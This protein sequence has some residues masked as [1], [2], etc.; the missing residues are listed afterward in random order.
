[1]QTGDAPAVTVE[2][3][4]LKLGEGADVGPVSVAELLGSLLEGT[5]FGAEFNLLRGL[6]GSFSSL[7]AAVQG[8]KLPLTVLVLA[9]VALSLLVALFFTAGS[10]SSSSS[11]SKKGGSAT[12]S[13]KGGSAAVQED[14][15][16]EPQRDFTLDQLREFTGGE[17]DKPIY[18]SLRG[19]VYDVS[20]AREFYG[21]GN[22]YHCFVGREASRAMAKL[23][24]DEE[25]LSNT[26][27]DDLNAMELDILDNWID[28]FKNYKCYPVR[29]RCTA[30]P[31]PRKFTLDE[32][33]AFKG[34]NQTAAVPAGRLHAPI[35]LGIN[36]KVLDVSYGGREN[37]GPGGPYCVLTGVDASR[38]LAKMSFDPKDLASRELGDLSDLEK[39][40]LA[41]WE[42]RL[43]KK[44][45]VV[46]TIA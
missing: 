41:D 6:D 36:G 46:G 21:K 30:P 45:P 33:A 24:F 10:S 15:N 5:A 42:A 39:K 4:R 2:N 31:A 14:E 28:K 27:L 34:D 37:Y 18:V 3:G 11:S 20:S 8:N 43:S 16:E 7:L 12:G 13:A 25:V 9:S 17:G 19:V 22:S 38:A 32:I 1:M 40:A 29:G 44:Y 35:L 23:S 26:R